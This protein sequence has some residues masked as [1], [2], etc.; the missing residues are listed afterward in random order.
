MGQIHDVKRL[1]RHVRQRPATQLRLARS[2]SAPSFGISDVS[3]WVFMQIGV[4]WLVF[5]L[6]E[7]VRLSVAKL[8][9]G[10]ALRVFF[11]VPPRRVE[12]M[13]NPPF[14]KSFI[15]Y[16]NGATISNTDTEA[17][18]CFDLAKV[19]DDFSFRLRASLPPITI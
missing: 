15:L 19:N 1:S 2:A 6:L 3:M 4:I 5:L 14:R 13:W 9:F 8:D 12:K 7:I 16:G 11:C 17:F 18:P 10:R